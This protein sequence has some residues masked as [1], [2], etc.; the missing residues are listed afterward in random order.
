MHIKDLSLEAQQIVASR[1]Y[2]ALLKQGKTTE[3]AEKMY[4][5]CQLWTIKQVQIYIDISDV[6]KG[7]KYASR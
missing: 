7:V 3:Q 4:H 5:N 6:L 1:L 2:F